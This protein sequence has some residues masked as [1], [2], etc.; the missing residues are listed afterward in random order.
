MRPLTFG[1]G[2]SHLVPSHL[3]LLFSQGLEDGGQEE[4]EKLAQ[5]PF[6]VTAHQ[7]LLQDLCGTKTDSQ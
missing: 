3:L 1:V 4:E 6:G 7:R 5:R 2:L